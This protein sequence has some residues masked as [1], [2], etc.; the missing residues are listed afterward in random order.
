MYSRIQKL[1]DLVVRCAVFLEFKHSLRKLV[2]T[3][4]VA[5]ATN[6]LKQSNHFVDVFAF[7]Q[8]RDALQVSAATVDEAH[9][10]QLIVLVNLKHDCS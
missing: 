9:V 5:S 3:R 6:P 7:Y 1:S 2:G 10:V 8:F 4:S